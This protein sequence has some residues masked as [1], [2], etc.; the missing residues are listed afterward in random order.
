MFFSIDIWPEFPDVLILLLSLISQAVDGPL[1]VRL[2][3]LASLNLIVESSDLPLLFFISNHESD[4][5]LDVNDAKPDE[6]KDISLC[7]LAKLRESFLD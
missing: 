1:D 7:I 6:D 4:E 5:F 2:L 3:K